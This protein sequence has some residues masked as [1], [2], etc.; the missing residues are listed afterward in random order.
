VVITIDAD[1]DRH[2]IAIEV[3]QERVHHYQEDHLQ[4]DQEMDG[5]HVREVLHA[6]MI[7]SLMVHH[8]LLGDV[9]DHHRYLQIDLRARPLKTTRVAHPQDQ[10]TVQPHR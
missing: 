2:M 1:P 6:E 10:A 8:H 3:H 4:L 9:H 5:V 7:V